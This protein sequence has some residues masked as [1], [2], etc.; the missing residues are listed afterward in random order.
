MNIVLFRNDRKVDKYKVERKVD[1]NPLW[2]VSLQSFDGFRR[3][4]AIYILT[5]L[6]YIFLKL[7]FSW[8][9]SFSRISSCDV[10]IFKCR[11]PTF[12]T[13]FYHFHVT[14]HSLIS[15]LQNYYHEIKS[16]STKSFYSFIIVILV[17]ILDDFLPSFLFPR[18]RLPSIYWS[19]ITSKQ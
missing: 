4:A 13:L 1:G 16:C 18:V 7:W 17:S 2:S 8:V 15:S 3:C 9:C 19:E 11:M 12:L 6:S 14:Y 5:I 10:T